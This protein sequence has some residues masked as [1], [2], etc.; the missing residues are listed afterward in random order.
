[1]SAHPIHAI[2]RPDGKLMTQFLLTALLTGPLFPIVILPL[3]FKFTTLRY[4]F[5][6]EGIAMSWG[7]LWRQ[8][9]HLT[10]ARIQDIHLSRGLIERWLGLAT[11]QIQT[12]SG[13]AGAEMALVGLREHQAVRDYLYSKMRGARGL[14]STEATGEREQGPR[15]GRRPAPPRC[16]TT[17][18]PSACT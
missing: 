7:V 6:D 18:A 12:A 14:T 3:Y 13:S 11:I 16:A 5:D 10:Y 17:C 8:E 9:V 15:R 4:R 2:E 1:M